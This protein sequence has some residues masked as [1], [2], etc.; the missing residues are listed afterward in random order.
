MTDT[1]DFE[2]LTERRSKIQ[3]VLVQLHSHA[4]V[5]NRAISDPLEAVFQLLLGSA[6]SL[7]R[8]VFLVDQPRTKTSVHKDAITFLEF[9][10][11]DNAV[12]YPQD[13]RT[14][15][16]TF[17]YY[18]NNAFLRLRLLVTDRLAEAGI[19]PPPS[20]ATVDRFRAM[21]FLERAKADPRD[22]WDQAYQVTYE[23]VKALRATESKV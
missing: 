20:C 13:R 18:L 5:R 7:W 22:L 3:A 2:W 16:W 10:I 9:V 14:Q 23:L 1:R 21:S 19:A 6:F 8:A 15:A 4:K 17:G 12:N 11:G